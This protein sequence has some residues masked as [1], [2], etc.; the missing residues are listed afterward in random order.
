[1]AAPGPAR[2]ELVRHAQS[3]GNVARDDAE[4]A[5]REAIEVGDRDMDVALSA[6]GRD[7]A[8]ALGRWLASRPADEAPTVVYSSPYRRAR[9]TAEIALAGCG[10]RVAD[11]PIRLDE[12]LRDRDLGALDGLTGRGIRAKF[13]GEAEMRASVGKFY[14]RPPGG[15]AWTDVLL[16]LRSL[17]MSLRM[18]AAGERVMIFTHDVVV[19]LFRYLLEDFDEAAA[20]ALSRDDPVANASVTTYRFDDGGWQ[21]VRYNHVCQVEE[22][23]APAT[24]E[25]EERVDAG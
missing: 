3:V 1:M 14:H 5:G 25:P 23:G 8:G 6:L 10:G 12:R 7:Q 24:V 4:A 2:I 16:R 15:E 22:H 9:Q 13:P 20:L 11:L 17:V 18:D 21:L 19:V